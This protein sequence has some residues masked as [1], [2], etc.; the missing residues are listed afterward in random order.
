MKTEF[1]Q[2][3]TIEISERGKDFEGKELTKFSLK[4]H[5]I[6]KLYKTYYITGC[7]VAGSVNLFNVSTNKYVRCVDLKYIC[8]VRLNFGL[9]DILD[10]RKKKQL[11]NVLIALLK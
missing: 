10:Y 11:K 7:P 1:K 4:P 9:L 2:T 6:V 3:I 8:L 5:T